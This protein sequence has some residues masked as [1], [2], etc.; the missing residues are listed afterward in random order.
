MGNMVK[1]LGNLRESIP[2]DEQYYRLAQIKL[3]YVKRGD[4]W[5]CGSEY[6]AELKGLKKGNYAIYVSGEIRASVDPFGEYQKK[7]TSDDFVI[8]E[9]LGD[10][11]R[12]LTDHYLKDTKV[13]PFVA[14]K[15][16]PV[17]Y[18]NL[19]VKSGST[20]ASKGDKCYFKEHTSLWAVN[21]Q[22][23]GL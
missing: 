20:Q 8:A 12:D 10:N 13:S 17:L 19:W 1:S 9:N 14:L 2:I 5:Q 16:Y 23:F 21:T 3:T 7:D 6:Q 22:V 18:I 4:I 11:I 15:D